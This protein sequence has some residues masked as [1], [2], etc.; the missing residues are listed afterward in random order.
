MTVCEAVIFSVVYPCKCLSLNFQWFTHSG[1]FD[2]WKVLL[3]WQLLVLKTGDLCALFVVLSMYLSYSKGWYPRSSVVI[4]WTVVDLSWS[5]SS[6]RF[7][8]NWK[9][10][11][12]NFV[13]YVTCCYD[14]SQSV[15]KQKRKGDWVGVN[16]SVYRN[17]LGLVSGGNSW[18]HLNLPRE[19]KARK[20]LNSKKRSNF[21]KNRLLRILGSDRLTLEEGQQNRQQEH[22]RMFRGDDQWELVI[23]CGPEIL[24]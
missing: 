1:T 12:N 9:R 6:C 14:I 3:L 16:D 11:V 20:P 5:K 10:L 8:K 22:Q 15:C 17:R 18:D 4:A 21:S 2:K 13:A 24:T 19:G 23:P 7:R